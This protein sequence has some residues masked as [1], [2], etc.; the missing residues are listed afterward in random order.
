MFF[1]SEIFFLYLVDMKI[2]QMLLRHCNFALYCI[3]Y[4]RNE[5]Y[6]REWNDSKSFVIVLCG[7]KL[8]HVGMT[9]IPSGRML[10]LYQMLNV[11]SALIFRIQVANS[12]INLH[13]RYALFSQ[14]ARCR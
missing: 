12:L 2:V 5:L 14:I 3:Q 8:V 7:V 1:V 9:L 6:S 13:V 10:V 4:F 11:T